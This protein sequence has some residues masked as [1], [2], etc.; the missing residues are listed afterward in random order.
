MKMTSLLFHVNNVLS[1]KSHRIG[2]EAGG[3]SSQPHDPLLQQLHPLHLSFDG[4]LSQC[5]IAEHTNSEISFY[6]LFDKCDSL[7]DL[8][9]S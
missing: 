5:F 9:S 6:M 3:D 2:H 8:E 4:R 7:R 1:L